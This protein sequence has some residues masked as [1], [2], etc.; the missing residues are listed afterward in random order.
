MKVAVHHGTSRCT[1]G[2]SRY[3]VYVRFTTVQ[4]GVRAVH[5]GTRRCTYGTIGGV[6]AVQH[7]AARHMQGGTHYLHINRLL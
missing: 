3:K 7:C 6:R 5:H 2:T 1:C 4:G